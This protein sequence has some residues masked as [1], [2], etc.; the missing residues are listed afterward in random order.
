MNMI[1]VDADYH[2]Q[3]MMTRN[4]SARLIGENEYLLARVQTLTV[5]N[6]A[7]KQLVVEITDAIGKLGTEFN[8]LKASTM[9]SLSTVTGY[10]TMLCAA[11]LCM[12]ETLIEKSKAVAFYSAQVDGLQRTVNEAMRKLQE[13]TVTS[14]IAE[15]LQSMERKT[16]NMPKDFN[17]L[18]QRVR[19]TIDKAHVLLAYIARVAGMEPADR[20]SG[21]LL[22]KYFLHGFEK[23]QDGRVDQFLDVTPD[24]SAVLKWLA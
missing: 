9:S 4:N 12:K 15:L 13:P 14:N 8:V 22:G 6:D 7:N 17:D 19:F 21:M 18:Y 23:A 24:V 11:D 5:E 20:E 16:I 1:F 3:L 2:R 10:V